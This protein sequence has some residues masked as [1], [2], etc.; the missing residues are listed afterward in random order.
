MPDREIKSALGADAEANAYGFIRNTFER[1]KNDGK[2]W[3]EIR[4]RTNGKLS[5]P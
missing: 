1:L 2:K 3:S 4:A 5:E